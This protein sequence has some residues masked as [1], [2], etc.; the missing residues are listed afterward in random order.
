MLLS[1]LRDGHS[2]VEV[3]MHTDGKFHFFVGMGWPG[4]N[5][6]KNNGNGYDTPQK[7]LAASKRLER[8]GK[9]RRAVSQ[10][11]PKYNKEAVERAIRADPSIGRKESTNIHRLLRGRH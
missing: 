9:E 8:R 1:E 7:A 3:R 5:L 11:P 6:P 10:Y 4:F 2:Q